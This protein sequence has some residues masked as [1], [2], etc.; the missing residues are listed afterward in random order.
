MVGG[1]VVAVVVVV[2]VCVG[3]KGGG[4]LEQGSCWYGIREVTCALAMTGW[5]G[6]TGVHSGLWGIH[7]QY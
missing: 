2:C 5:G 3:M 6:N 7:S 1:K 4:E